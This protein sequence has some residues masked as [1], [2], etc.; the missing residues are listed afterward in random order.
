MISIF[1]ILTILSIV[2]CIISIYIALYAT[3]RFKGNLRKAVMPLLIV[4]GLLL[5]RNIVRLANL[6]PPSQIEKVNLGINF[7]VTLLILI[8]MLNFR[9]V[10]KTVD[11]R[12]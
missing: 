8:S 12:K 4:L 5:I 11:G 10:V 7:L 3:G 9:K 2:F 1:T 6:I